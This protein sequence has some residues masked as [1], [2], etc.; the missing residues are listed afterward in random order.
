LLREDFAMTFI[1]LVVDDEEADV[2]RF[3]RAARK[4]GVQRRI[5]IRRDGA[6]AF[7]LLASQKRQETADPGYLLVS[8]LKMPIMRGTELVARLRTELGLLELPAFIMSSSDSV[9]DVEEAL[10]SGANGYILKCESEADYLNVV[11]WLDGC[12][13]QFEQGH[14]LEDA[15]SFSEGRPSQVI[16]GPVLCRRLN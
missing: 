14:S 4:A 7:G 1:M 5:E 16:A 12:C 13:G 6:E 11:R 3:K 9:A 8:D 15:T 2:I 10:S